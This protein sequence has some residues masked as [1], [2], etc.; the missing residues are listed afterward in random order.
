MNVRPDFGPQSVTTVA[1][2]VRIHT[3]PEDLTL[4]T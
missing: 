1:A 4:R 3:T 2:P